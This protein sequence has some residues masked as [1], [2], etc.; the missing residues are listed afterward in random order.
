MR[1]RTAIFATFLLLPAALMPV[2]ANAAVTCTYISAA[3]T[4]DCST[5]TVGPV[6]VS[7][8]WGVGGNLGGTWVSPDGEPPRV[9]RRVFVLS[10]A[11][12]A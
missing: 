2:V 10:Q 12:I 3:G 9:L 5:S 4:Y 8:D 7:W 1:K 11:A 6:G